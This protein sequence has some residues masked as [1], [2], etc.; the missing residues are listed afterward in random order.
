MRTDFCSSCSHAVVCPHPN[1]LAEMQ[2]KI[3][4]LFE[5]KNLSDGKNMNFIEP[6]DLKCK[7]YSS[8]LNQKGET[9]R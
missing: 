3:D 1:E 8:K 2:A 4:S 7:F 9:I 5:S 6:V